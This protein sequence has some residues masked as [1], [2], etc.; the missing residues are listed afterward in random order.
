MTGVQTCALPISHPCFPVTIGGGA[1]DFVKMAMIEID[2]D[3]EFDDLGGKLL[4]QVHDELVVEAPI[5]NADEAEKRMGYLM[6]NFPIAKR[7]PIPFTTE[8]GWSAKNW[9]NAKK[10]EKGGCGD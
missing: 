3:P 4:L 10:A 8:G 2:N 7:M 1:A 9:W 5:E 6:S